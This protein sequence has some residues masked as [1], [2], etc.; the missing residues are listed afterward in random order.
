MFLIHST[1]DQAPL[2]AAA[3][4]GA[5]RGDGWQTPLQP[6]FLGV[7]FHQRSVTRPIS[8]RSPAYPPKPWPRPCPLPSNGWSWWS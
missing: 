6:R 4:V 7:L 5:C 1:L 3:L 2:Q 8:I